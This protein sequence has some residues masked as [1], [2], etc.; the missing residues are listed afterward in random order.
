M[1]DPLKGIFTDPIAAI[2]GD[3]AIVRARDGS[4]IALRCG[5]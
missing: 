4:S 3:T 1:F 5:T 2:S